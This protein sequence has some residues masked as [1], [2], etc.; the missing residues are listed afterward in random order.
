MKEMKYDFHKPNVYNH[1]Q[2]MFCKICFKDFLF[3]YPCALSL[4]MKGGTVG[5]DEI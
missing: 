2:K 1:I 3:I 4:Y 5:I